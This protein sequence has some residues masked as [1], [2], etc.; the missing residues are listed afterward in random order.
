[1][2]G[3]LHGRTLLWIQLVQLEDIHCM[4]DTDDY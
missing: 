4:K 2:K 1:M 3:K